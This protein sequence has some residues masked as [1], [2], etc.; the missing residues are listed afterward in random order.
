MICQIISSGGVGKVSAVIA[1][2]GSL[3]NFM[4]SAVLEQPAAMLHVEAA[5][6]AQPERSFID[7][8]RNSRLG[9]G[10][11]A[12]ALTFGFGGAAE[13]VV[14]T[15]SASAAEGPQATVVAHNASANASPNN[16]WTVYGG[17]PLFPGGVHSKK[18]F[19]RDILS[20]KGQIALSDIGLNPTDIRAVDAVA[21][22][23]EKGKKANIT[24]RHFPF[25]TFFPKMT[26][27]VGGGVAVDE[28]GAKF[29][30]RR[31]PHGFDA[32]VLT[33]KVVTHKKIEEKV[34]GKEVPANETLTQTFEIAGPTNCVNISPVAEHVTKL[35]VPI[36]TKGHKTPN[37]PVTP[38]TPNTPGSVSPAPVTQGPAPQPGITITKQFV[39]SI[40]PDG[41][42]DST[43]PANIAQDGDTVEWQS[44]VTNTGNDALAT[45]FTDVPPQGESIL[46][47]SMPAN[48]AIDPSSGDATWTGMGILQPGQSVTINYDTMANA[49]PCFTNTQNTIEVAGRDSSNN[50]VNAQ[51]VAYVKDLASGPDCINQAPGGGGQPLPSS[52][53]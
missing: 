9:H 4:N 32:Y 38:L 22:N 40:S 39:E 25:G 15:A 12:V 3:N 16:D 7:A 11:A 53:Y 2:T 49:I 27:G 50:T 44:V 41:S 52:S 18:Q 37:K 33:A 17:A 13:G 14:A 29:E 24:L 45:A 36:K 43:A 35:V 46:L 30:D 10:L 28:Q 42:I 5:S 48:T 6:Q 19:A 47:S 1:Q 51:A 21:T 34:K 20:R 23:A 8:L 31:F 26:Y